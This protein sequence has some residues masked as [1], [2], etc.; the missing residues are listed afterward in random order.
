MSIRV[1]IVEDEA[2]IAAAL[3]VR[4]QG[5]GYVVSG[6]AS[7]AEQAIAEVS[8]AS[9]DVVLMDIQLS[10]EQRGIQAAQTIQEEMG[11]PVVFTTAYADP[12]TIE[13][14]K[15]TEPYGYLLKP[16]D[17]SSLK[18]AIELAVYRHR[19]ERERRLLERQLLQSQKMESVGRL[20]GG[21]A[22]DFNNLLAVIYGISELISMQP[23]M[24]P[25]LQ[26]DL[27][28]AVDRGAALIRRLMLFSRPETP[29]LT[30]VDVGQAL[31]SLRKLL[32]RLL[33]T[34]VRLVIQLPPGTIFGHLDP[35]QLDQLIMNLVVNARD[36]MPQGGEVVLSSHNV[37]EDWLEIHVRDS[38]VGISP[39]HLDQIFE[40]FFSTKDPDAGTGLGLSVVRRIVQGCGG[41]ISVRSTIGLGTTFVVRL[42]RASVKQ[43][44]DSGEPEQTPAPVLMPAPEPP[45]VERASARVLI[46][47]DEN[48]VR[49][50]TAMM[51]RF[52]G[53]EVT[54]ADGAGQALSILSAGTAS[55]DLLLTDVMMPY[56]RGPELAAVL[57]RVHPTLRVGY[58]SGF[59]GVLSDVKPLL[60]KP[61]RRD[62]LLRFVDEQLR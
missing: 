27:Q 6:M 57:R 16:Y 36:A 37:D 52:A 26:P 61:F 3:S 7:S 23:Q 59:T 5:L 58:I 12:A 15:L 49:S 31:S 30:V 9:P 21:I 33:G 42:P 55:F 25:R 60:A 13:R 46:V 38:G 45:A 48:A 10:G 4:L 40:P 18:V 32:Q 50:V 43:Q 56:M 24:A 19:S 8:A 20:A 54:E 11:I 34:S 53:Y 28:A 62:A 14:A 17:D 2:I 29:R 44:A 22:H 47:D 1:L 51:L 35:L 41:E 39:E